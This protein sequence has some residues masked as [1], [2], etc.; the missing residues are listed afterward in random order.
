MMRGMRLGA[1]RTA[2][3]VGLVGLTA[4]ACD[5]GA[6]RT[7]AQVDTYS[8]ELRITA[9]SPGG[10]SALEGRLDFDRVARTFRLRS[11][12]GS[13]VLERDARGQTRLSVGSEEGPLDPQASQQVVLLM[14]VL[15]AEPRGGDDLEAVDGGYRLR[16]GGR[17]IRVET[18][19]PL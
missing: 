2:I 4:A 12:D 8:G 18:R 19:P 10:A 14:T 13:R 11:A 17:E 6:P 9:S 3:L 5:D 7:F 15:F 1:V 16:S